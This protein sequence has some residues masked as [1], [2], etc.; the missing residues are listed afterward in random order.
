M[1]KIRSYVTPQFYIKYKDG[2]SVNYGTPRSLKLPNRSK[3]WKELRRIF[4]TESEI[5]CI[6]WKSTTR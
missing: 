4:N 1:R 2:S 6:G 3:E 5:E